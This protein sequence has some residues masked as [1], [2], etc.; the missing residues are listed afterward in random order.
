MSWRSGIYEGWVQ[1]RRF[2][3]TPN[4]FRYRLFMMYL[5]LA[6]LGQLFEKRWFW[7]ERR[8]AQ[9]RFRRDD[10]FGAPDVPLDQAVRD[11]AED[12]L[13]RRPLG[14]IGVLTHLRYFG[15]VINPISVFYCF[16]KGSDRIEAIVLEVQNTP[17]RE[18]HLYVLD[19]T[20]QTKKNRYHI[21]KDF[22]VSP[23]LA[24]DLD[25]DM[26][27]TPPTERLIAHM[28][29]R[30]GDQ[31][32]LDATLHMHRT[33]ITGRALARVLCQYPVMTLKVAAGIYWQAL[34]LW[35]KKCPFFPHPGPKAPPSEP[36]VARA[37]GE[38]VDKGVS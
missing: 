8:W 22:H 23:F 20:L 24:M 13:G 32:H 29:C 30:R 38:L 3:V 37:R 14:R 6:E 25:Y 19:G 36:H 33:E 9:A 4:A 26:V 2:A 31:I 35:L 15:F 27:I 18:R 12:R 5:D 7:S 10:H 34:R 11:L 21:A 17:W 28:D 1:H 16:E